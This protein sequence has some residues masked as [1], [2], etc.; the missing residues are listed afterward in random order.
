MREMSLLAKESAIHWYKAIEDGSAWIADPEPTYHLSVWFDD[1]GWDWHIL[2]PTGRERDWGW[3]ESTEKAA[4][5]AAEKA[6]W[7]RKQA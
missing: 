6:Y 3:A 2:D 1:R 7:A 5:A 4:K